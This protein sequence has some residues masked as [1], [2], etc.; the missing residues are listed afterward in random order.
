MRNGFKT[1]NWNENLTEKE[2]ATILTSGFVVFLKVLNK[3]ALVY[4]REKPL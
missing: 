3:E 1:I 2:S 4:K